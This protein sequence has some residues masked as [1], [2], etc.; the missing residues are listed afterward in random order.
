ME[1]LP[2]AARVVIVGGGMAGLQLAGELSRLGVADLLVIEAGPNAGSAHINAVNDPEKALRLW[3]EPGL[4]PH[5]WRPWRSTTPPHYDTMS[6]M[7][8]RVGGRSLYWHGV[9]L[10]VEDWAL[11][12]GAWPASVVGELTESWR[13]GPSLYAAVQRDL[14]AW[15]GWPQQPARSV[16]IGPFVLRDVPRAARILPGGRFAAY[17][18]AEAFGDTPFRLLS[19]LEVIGLDC[20]DDQIRGVRV[21][22]GGRSHTIRCEVAVLAA[23]TIENSRL[24]IQ[25]LHPMGT[26]PEPELDGLVDHI[27][28]GFLATAD[29]ADVP[30]DLLA[31]ADADTFLLTPCAPDARANL[32]VRL[33]RNRIGA[34]VL[35]VWTMGE[36]V[37]GEHAAVVCTPAQKR[38]WPVTIRA[39]CC[40]ADRAAIAA[41]RA[42]LQEFWTAFAKAADLTPST[43]EFP[44][45]D[46]P[47]RTLETVMPH[48]DDLSAG[49][50]AVTWSGPLGSEYHESSTLPLGG[51]VTERQEVIGL[52]D[53]YVAGPAVYPRPGAANPTLTSLALTKRLAYLLRDALAGR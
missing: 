19:D 42:E 2:E 52:R 53:V 13:G 30:A 21:D 7:R 43:L 38:P 45:F 36:Q 41:H 49:A 20:E 29:P 1:D 25:A 6:A 51:R 37:P 18:P 5:Y 9:I 15:C 12:G 40:Q 26:L 11:A 32:F 31:L 4:D 28:N 16:H 46:R 17:S 23:G 39:A 47:D 22:A 27:V 33:Y 34:V 24:V 35:D 44:D 3:L 50:P 8:R 14:H 48:I 10:P